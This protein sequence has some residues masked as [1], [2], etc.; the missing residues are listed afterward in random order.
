MFV[1]RKKIPA[2]T[3]QGKKVYEY[4]YLV[5]NVWEDGRTR[6]RDVVY[7]GREPVITLSQ[8]EARGLDLQ[9]LKRIEGL[10]IEV[11]EDQEGTYGSS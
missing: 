4:F 8:I 9:E 5:E 10:K 6:Q 7:L 2:R 11:S 1:R 3:K